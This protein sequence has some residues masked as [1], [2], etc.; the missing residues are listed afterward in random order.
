MRHLFVLA[1]LCLSA[2]GQGPQGIPGTNGMPSPMGPQ[3]PGGSVITPVQFCPGSITS[4]P[5]TYAEVGLCINNNIWA[6]YSANDGFLTEIVP[7]YYTS[8]AIGSSC[9]FTVLPNCVISN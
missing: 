4:Y 9:N 6:V 5:T 8:N 7:G 1:C 2:C 3:Y